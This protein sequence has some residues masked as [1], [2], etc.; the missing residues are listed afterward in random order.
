LQPNSH[1][2]YGF[3]VH[4]NGTLAELHWFRIDLT[5]RRKYSV[6]RLASAQGEEAARRA[7]PTS[8]VAGFSLRSSA[9]GGAEAP[10]G[11]SQLPW[12]A[13]WGNRVR[14]VCLERA[15]GRRR[16]VAG[17]GRS[18]GEVAIAASPHEQNRIRLLFACQGLIRLLF[19]YAIP[20]ENTR[21][22]W[23][24]GAGIPAPSPRA[25]LY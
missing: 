11:D 24:S 8:S 14:L 15:S 22:P 21:L 7:M 23:K 10:L 3:T 17:F 4:R 6:P 5:G 12:R 25:L 19:A 1:P 13:A 16:S 20:S 9:G 18:M 2:R